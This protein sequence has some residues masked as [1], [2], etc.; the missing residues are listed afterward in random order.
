MR[1][2]KV[3]FFTRVVA[4]LAGATVLALATPALAAG[5]VTIQHS[6]G[7][8]DSYPNSPI[9]IIHDALYITSSDG[10]GTLVINRAAC[11]YQG[12]VMTCLPTSV[13][14]VQAGNTKKVDLQTGTLYLNLTDQNQ[15]LPLSSTQLPPHS[16]MFS[17][18]TLIGTVVNVSG[19]IDKVTK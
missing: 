14:L 19:A 5:T 1:I 8:V 15:Q 10:K 11:Y 9:H 2:T 3:A 13:A 17:F 7:N 18:S 6:D 12:N 4:L 16:I